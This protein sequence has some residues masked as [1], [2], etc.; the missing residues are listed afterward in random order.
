MQS[1]SLCSK[2]CEISQGVCKACPCLKNS[3]IADK[4][5]GARNTP[6]D[7]KAFPGASSS[8]QMTEY[9]F[10]STIVRET[11][12]DRSVGGQSAGAQSYF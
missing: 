7:D 1:S 9:L 8:Q 11:L 6:P 5:T 12:A 4:A 2:F 3:C 10:V